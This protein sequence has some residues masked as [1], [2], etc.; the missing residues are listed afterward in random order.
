MSNDTLRY[1]TGRFRPT[2]GP[3]DADER[4]AL[5]QRIADVPGLLEKA[6]SGLGDEQLDTPYREGGW[7]P[8]Q[9]THHIAD[10][11][12][13]SFVRFKLAITEDNPTIRTYEQEL[14]AE[15]ADVHAVPVEASLAIVRGL[16][17]RW[18]ALLYSFGPEDFR[19]TVQHPEIGRIDL[20][21]LLQLYA[22]HGHHHV[23]HIEG[24]RARRGW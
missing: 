16:H 8:R 18:V 19:R 10:S 3:L 20:D 4:V 21:Y 11:H 24:L 2:D 6:V 5:I 14:W 1:P 13:N 15:T 23:A 17:Q 12:L 9:S 22:W 7:S